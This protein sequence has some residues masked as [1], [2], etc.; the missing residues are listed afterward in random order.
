MK[1]Y[2]KIYLFL[3]ATTLATL[4]LT[5]WVS[6]SVLPAFSERQRTQTLDRFEEAVLSGNLTSREEIQLLADSMN[7]G[8]R[9]V[10]GD[11]L[12]PAHQGQF[13]PPAG[14][15]VPGEMDWRSVRLIP[16]PGSQV[17]ILANARIRTP[18]FAIFLLFALVLFAS[19]AAALSLGLKSVFRRTSL[20]TK[21]TG[22]FGR[23]QLSSRYP[24]HGSSDEIDEL[25]RAFNL[26]A[27]RIISLLDS[28]NELLNAVAHELRTPMARLSFA[29][30]LARTN[31]ESVRE[32]LG[33][34]EKD[35]FELDTLVSELLEFNR[36]RNSEPGTET[37]S[38][39]D[40][41][42]E[43]AD[44]E[45]VHN[46]V[47]DISV[48]TETANN[49]VGGDYRLLLRAV[50]NLVRNAVGYASSAVEVSVASYSDRVTVSVSDDGP[51]FPKGF[52]ERAVDPFAKGENSKGSGLGLSI[53]KRIAEKH[54]GTLVLKNTGSGALAEFTIPK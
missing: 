22:D 20:L 5:I 21:A 53:V 42:H 15:H 2:W 19:Q 39:V 30:E 1:L 23:G 11:H 51:G 32:K 4:V 54:G 24:D 46:P 12:P 28:H 34:M 36:I 8:L 26:M 37:V 38:M 45:M 33:L 43:A 17:S 41:C 10:Q 31:P 35:L 25:G 16:V 6:F 27:E 49:S 13:P 3:A 52:S 18:R 47:V 48:L 50:S 7:I 29:I 40:I 9:L 14:Q 44:A